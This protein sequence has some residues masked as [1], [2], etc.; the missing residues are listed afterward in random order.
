MLPLAPVNFVRT[1][2]EVYDWTLLRTRFSVPQMN[3]KRLHG[4]GVPTGVDKL[5]VAFQMA[6]ETRRE[7]VNPFPPT[8]EW[9]SPAFPVKED[10]VDTTG[11]G[12]SFLLGPQTSRSLPPGRRLPGLFPLC[13]CPVLTRSRRALSL[14]PT[15]RAR[16]ETGVDT[17]SVPVLLFCFRYV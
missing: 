10:D 14:T 2:I 12:K 1:S 15:L 8:E 3:L 9:C 11:P 6:C 4:L 16:R 13:R 5:S 17:G 7:R